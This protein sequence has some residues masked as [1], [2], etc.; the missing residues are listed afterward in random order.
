MHLAVKGEELVVHG[1]SPGPIIDE[2]LHHDS[3]LDFPILPFAR[4]VVI[5]GCQ[6]TIAGVEQ[7]VD[8]QCRLVEDY[9]NPP[10]SVCRFYHESS[11]EVCKRDR[12]RIAGNAVQPGQDLGAQPLCHVLPDCIFVR[13][14]SENGPTVKDFAA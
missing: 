9:A 12:E 1:S 14:L 10:A 11:W 3:G 8:V 7:L 5:V 13:E 4:S 6:P 2:F